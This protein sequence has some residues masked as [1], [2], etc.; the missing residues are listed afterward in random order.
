MKTERETTDERR[1]ATKG[2]HTI[3]VMGGRRFSP[4]GNLK[5]QYI[6]I[7]TNQVEKSNWTRLET[8]RGSL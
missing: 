7:C 2:T 8:R 1:V 3:D 4:M 5:D 6:N